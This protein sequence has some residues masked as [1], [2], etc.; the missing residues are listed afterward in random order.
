ML[1]RSA[2]KTLG[3]P[4]SASAANVTVNIIDPGQ[5]YVPRANMLDLR[6]GKILRFGSRRA[7]VNLDIHN[8][9]NRSAVLLQNDNYASWQTPQSIMDGRL[10]KLSANL[11]F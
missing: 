5:Y 11:D 1:F 6:L 9:F 8:I 4:L 3:R 2:A 10:F 7:S